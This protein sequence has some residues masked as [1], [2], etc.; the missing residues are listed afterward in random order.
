[1]NLLKTLGLISYVPHLFENDTP[2]AEVVHPYG[3][4]S[5][6]EEP[7][8]REIGEAADAAGREM[9]AFRVEHGERQGFEYL[10]PVPRTLPNVKLA[11]LPGFDTGHRLVGQAHGIA[12]GRKRKNLARKV[13]SLAGEAEVSR[14]EFS[15]FG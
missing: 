6:G 9:A 5:N 14:P 13:L 8:E 10:C 2:Q 11:E 1:M 7:I 12:V 3:M 4:G 15:K